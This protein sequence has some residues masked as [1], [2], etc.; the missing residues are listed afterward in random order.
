VA[1]FA[2]RFAR[3]G[4]HI[5]HG[6]FAL[7]KRM[8]ESGEIDHLVPER[9]WTETVKALQTDNPERYFEVL[10]RC[11]ALDRL[12]PE[13]ARLFGVPQPAHWHPEGD[14][15]RHS[16]LALAAAAR[17]TPDPRVR[18]AALV[19]DLGK[20]TTPGDRLPHHHRH[21]QRGRKLI[22]AMARRLKIPNDYRD[23]ALLTARWHSHVHRALELRPATLLQ[24]LEGTDAYRRPERFEQFLLAC[25]ADA[26]GRGQTP[27]PDYPQ[28]TLMRQAL[29]VTRDID[30]RPFL[31]QGIEGP[32]LGERVRQARLAALRRLRRTRP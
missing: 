27:P 30:A 22:E 20:G 19:H 12:F 5:A 23:L 32:A 2:A 31:A 6:T 24:V 16:L 7:M 15:G 10:H 26:Q 1:R 8:V 25:T 13:L 29:A 28:A 3:W 9:V 18:F 21:E 4:F 17:L 14:A 11:G